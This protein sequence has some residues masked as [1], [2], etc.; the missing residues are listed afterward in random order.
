MFRPGRGGSRKDAGLLRFTAHARTRTRARTFHIPSATKAKRNVTPNNFAFQAALGKRPIPEAQ[1]II[2]EA[3]TKLVEAKEAHEFRLMEEAKG[4]QVPRRNWAGGDA[5]AE[6]LEQAALDYLAR[7]FSADE[8]R[9][10]TPLIA[11][12]VGGDWAVIKRSA[13]RPHFMHSDWSIVKL[14]HGL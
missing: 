4:R 7:N 10:M 13:P 5:E 6:K 3:T 14:T 9:M 12:I 1:S 2:T 8:G 11:R